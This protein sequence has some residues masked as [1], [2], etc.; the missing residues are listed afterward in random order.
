MA[1]R[2]RISDVDRCPSAVLPGL[3]HLGVPTFRQLQTPYARRLAKR[4][5]TRAGTLE[6]TSRNG[7]AVPT[8]QIPSDRSPRVI[9]LPP[10]NVQDKVNSR[11]PGRRGKTCRSKTLAWAPNRSVRN[12]R[13]G[14]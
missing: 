3:H 1:R 10:L 9:R 2:Y 8:F 12:E 4:H 11:L 5:A 14:A 13:R 7:L 6:L